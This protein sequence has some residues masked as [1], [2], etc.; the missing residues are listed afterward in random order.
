MTPTEGTLVTVD[1]TP[2]LRFERHYRHPI[3]RVWRAVTDPAEVGRWFPSEVV[4]DRQVGAELVFRDDAQRAADREAGEPTRADGPVISGRVIAHDPPNVW[5]FS[6]GG[7][8]LR[9]EL[10]PEGEGT[11]LVFTQLLSHQ[12]VAAR[13]GAGWHAC[14]AELDGLLG[15]GAPGGPKG[16]GDWMPVYEDY[17]ERVGPQLG[18]PSGGG[19]VTWERATHVDVARVAAATSEQAELEA[20]GA[21]EHRADR[22]RWEIEPAAH[23]TVYRLTV[24]DIG[25]DAERAATWH[26]L[27]LQLDMWLAAGQLVPVS[28]DR[29]VPAYSERWPSATVTGT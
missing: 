7:E 24:E 21:A 28:A 22:V 5:S 27:L 9:F 2:T 12:S 8:V 17:I 19:A 23:G 29:F 18:A 1:G 3:E 15:A 11:R 4:G 20:W 6:W 25:D 26:A 16:D 14:L 13:N 10:T